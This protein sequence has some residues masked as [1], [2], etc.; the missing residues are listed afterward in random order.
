MEHNGICCAGN[1]L[2]DKVKVIDTYPDQD[3]L[4]NIL[5][6]SLGTGGAPYN[7]LVD[8]AKMDS[9]LYLEG[10]GLIGRDEFGQY[11]LNDI[12]RYNIHPVGVIQTDDEPTSYTDV[13]TVISTGRRTFFHNRGANKLLDYEH[14]PFN[15]IGSGLLHTGY[16]LLLDK[17]DAADSEHGTVMA[18]V[19]ADAHAHGIKTSLDLVSDPNPERYKKVVYPSLKH[20]DYLIINEFEAEN[21]TG[22]GL[23]AAGESYHDF[24]EAADILFSEGVVGLVVIHMPQGGYLFSSKGDAVFQPSHLLPEGFIKGSVGAG[25]AFCAGILYGICRG[26]EYDEMMRIATA[27]AALN[28]SSLSSTDGIKSIEEIREFSDKTPYREAKNI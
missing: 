3:K 2:V 9:T 22:I 27:A 15:K 18:K 26:M 10:I 5:D 20:T 4:A 21:L 11:I 14:F 17:L 6:E 12:K 13:M 16:A 8:L 23:K 1:W 28:L 24:K 7:V 25:D 19:L